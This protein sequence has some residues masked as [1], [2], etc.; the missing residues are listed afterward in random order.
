MSEVSKW[1]SQTG[2]EDEFDHLSLAHGANAVGAY[3]DI[4]ESLG[5]ARSEHYGGYYVLTRYADIVAAA[6]D[7]RTFSSERDFNGPGLGGGGIAIPPNP[8]TR[9]SLDEMDPPEW[10]RL[11]SAL[12]P[13]LSPAAVEKIKPTI[14]EL[15]TYFIDQF[16]ESGEADLV[17]DLAASIPA[18]VTLD[19]VGLPRAEWESYADPIHKMA[20]VHRD[21]PE[22]APVYE[23]TLWILDQLRIEIVEHRREPKDDL[24][25]YL[26]RHDGGGVPFTDQEIWEMLYISLSGGIDTTTALMSN[27][28][29]YLHEH[30]AERRKLRDN[31]SLIDSACEEFL[32][33]FTPVQALART[34]TKPVQMCGVDMQRGDRVLLAWASA[35][36]DGDQFDDADEVQL[37]RFPN[38]HC[39]FGV[40]IHRCLGSNLARTVFKTV[41]P[42]F[43]RRVPD[44]Q[45]I[46]EG[47]RRYD[48]VGIVNGWEQMPIAFT[49][50]KREGTAS[51]IF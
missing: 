5:V 24:I 28:F 19:F 1:L 38:R 40:G 15:T 10:K 9:N 12:N 39:A 45:V 21:R 43:I 18:I 17:L 41:V 13:T 8:A 4:R 36:R 51:K 35:N 30:P 37:D 31:P 42:E 11:R 44:Y 22:Y 26:I 16:I 46:A 14:Q 33:A 20:Y 7:H 48:R 32:R 34:L 25:S 6:R 47:A 23:A 2:S 50:G 49:P 29:F 27:T 3:R